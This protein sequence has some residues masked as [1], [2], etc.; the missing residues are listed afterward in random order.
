M[1]DI[2]GMPE[3]PDVWFTQE[4]READQVFY[5]AEKLKAYI[6][7]QYR[8]MSM[9]SGHWCEKQ[10]AGSSEKPGYPMRRSGRL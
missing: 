7:G 8:F 10:M 3:E 9:E 4:E 6:K 2:A 5:D 1:E